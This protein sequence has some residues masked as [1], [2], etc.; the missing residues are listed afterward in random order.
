MAFHFATL[1]L[2]ATKSSQ[3]TP[4]VLSFNNLLFQFTSKL[5]IQNDRGRT[6][7][8]TNDSIPMFVLFCVI[9]C[10]CG[11]SLLCALMWTEVNLLAGV[12]IRLNCT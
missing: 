4:D 8:A 10:Q 7:E 1:P 3:W 11:I 6:E 12:V 9:S 5:E 2:G